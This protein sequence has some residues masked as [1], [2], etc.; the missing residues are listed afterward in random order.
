M[1][2]KTVQVNLLFKKKKKTFPT[3]KLLLSDPIPFPQQEEIHS[4]TTDVSN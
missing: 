1:F 2:H 4:K 3:P